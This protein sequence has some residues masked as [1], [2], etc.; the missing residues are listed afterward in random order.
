M[1]R[2]LTV[3]MLTLLP[4][5][6]HAAVPDG[7]WL[8][9][10]K[11]PNQKQQVKLH[12]V[13][14]KLIFDRGAGHEIVADIVMSDDYVFWKSGLEFEFFPKE[15]RMTRTTGNGADELTCARQP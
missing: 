11:D 5:S 15:N 1:R 7:K 3:L 9:S 8:C 13:S 14:G 12:F 6:A 2:L 4:V 10:Y